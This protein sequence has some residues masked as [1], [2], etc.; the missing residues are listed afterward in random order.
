MP[1]FISAHDVTLYWAGAAGACTAMAT[2]YFWRGSAAESYSGGVGWVLGLGWLMV[3]TALVAL[4]V[5]L[6]RGLHGDGPKGWL[7]AAVCAA[8]G[9]APAYFIA[10]WIITP[11][12]PGDPASPEL[13]PAW[14]LSKASTPAKAVAVWQQGETVVRVQEDGLSAYRAAD[15]SKLWTLATPT[16]ET[17]CA[18]AADP[19]GTVAVVALS[20][21]LGECESVR[22]VDLGTGKWAWGEKAVKITDPV[23]RERRSRQ[24]AVTGGTVLVAEEEQLRAL[25]AADG[26]DLWNSPATKGCDNQAVAAAAGKVALAEYCSTGYPQG[27]A[28][29]RMLGAADGKQAWRTDLGTETALTSVDVLSVQPPV[30]RVQERDL[31]GVRGVL[32]F[33]EQ[34]VV[35]TLVK[36]ATGSQLLALEPNSQ[37]ISAPVVRAVVT[38]DQL[39]AAVKTGIGG[40][41]VVGFSL[42]DGSRRWTVD[43]GSG[44]Y[45][46]AA[47]PDGVVLALTD[48]GYDNQLLRIDPSTGATRSRQ[49]LPTGHSSATAWLG[50]SATRYLIGYGLEDT[51]VPVLRGLPR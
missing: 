16:R 35:R 12:P 24:L 32:S 25:R 37:S 14:T 9:I 33:T 28:A 44:A 7:V 21:S 46:L 23:D 36:E 10:G 2:V 5:T 8:L 27:T 20:R 47:G 38:G 19:A 4:V 26:T 11:P 40:E 29:L 22:A 43:A 49:I 41:V 17:V 42:A 30:L 50:Q 48:Y 15:G 51:A 31:A 45:G 3:V 1:R 18:A 6:A 34:G 39:V 13:R